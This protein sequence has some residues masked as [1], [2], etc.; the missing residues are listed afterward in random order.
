MSESIVATTSGAYRGVHIDG[1]HSFLGVRYGSDTRAARFRPATAAERHE[2]V[3][4]ALAFGAAALQFDSRLLARSTVTG[5]AALYFPHGQQTEGHTVSE[6]C[7]TLNIWTPSVEPGAK[8]PVMVWFHGG[9]FRVG[10]A[11]ATV[12]HGANLAASGRAIVITVNTASGYPRSWRSA[13]CSVRIS[14]SR[15]SRASPTSPLRSS[16]SPRTPSDSGATRAT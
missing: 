9:A 10:S 15:V 13:T 11:A 14:R 8:L 16:G 12:T 1:V 7:L 5:T 4:D 6:D 2:G 3:V